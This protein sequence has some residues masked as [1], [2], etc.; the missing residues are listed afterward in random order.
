ML[1][2]H[3]A[4]AHA[5]HVEAFDLQGVHQPQAI[6]SHVIEA[7][8]RLYREPKLETHDLIRQVGSGRRLTPGAQA[9]VAVVVAD[10]SKALLA[11]GNH[12]LIRPVD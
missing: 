7:I 1:S 4:H 5:E 9:Y 2:N 8:R 11:Q 12:H 10:H 6:F 3:P